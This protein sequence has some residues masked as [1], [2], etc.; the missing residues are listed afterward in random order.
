MLFRKELAQLPPLTSDKIILLIVL[1]LLFFFVVYFELRILRT[2]SKEV[3]RASLAKDE[4]FN[5]VLTTRSVIVALQRQGT[6]ADKAQRLVDEAKLKLQR[7]DYKSC[8]DLCDEAKTELTNPGQT[9]APNK[10]R[11]LKA[12]ASSDEA[13]PDRDALLRMADEIVSSGDSRKT[14]DLY[15]GT[16]L[17]TDQDGNYLSARFEINKAKSDIQSAYDRGDDTSVAQ[18]LL[19]DAEKAFAA[20]TYT[21]ALSLAIKSRK[22][23]HQVA[24]NETIK[25]KT[26]PETDESARTTAEEISERSAD[27]CR[28]CGAV[29]DPDDAFCHKC[30]TRVDFERECEACGTVAKA[31]DT[32]CRKCGS[33]MD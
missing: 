33:K 19:T 7:G 8:K 5:A 30:G 25:L 13:E 6:N 20:G 14:S 16:R 31:E 17:Q 23:V 15:A 27:A 22:S 21:K 11:S 9:R 24:E 18:N 1:A 29:L 12:A 32:F 10:T 3:R 2:K 26:G 4:A 28:S